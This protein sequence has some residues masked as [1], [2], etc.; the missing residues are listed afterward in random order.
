[1][2]AVGKAKAGGDHQG[3]KSNKATTQ[4]TADKIKSDF[5]T[6]AQ[7]FSVRFLLS[8]ILRQ[9]ELNSSICE[10]MATFDPFILFKRPIDIALRH[11]DLIYSTFQWRS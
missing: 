11:L 8:R 1:M 3:K 10:E 2:Q 6:E 4:K 7:K 9:S 5:A